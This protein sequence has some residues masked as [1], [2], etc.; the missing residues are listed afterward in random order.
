MSHKCGSGWPILDANG[1]KK[2]F[3]KLTVDK[4]YGRL[5][6]CKSEY[7]FGKKG[8]TIDFM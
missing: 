5:E 2:K 6:F 7:S 1:D 3:G 4:G 8:A